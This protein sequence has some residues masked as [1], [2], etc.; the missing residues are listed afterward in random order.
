[1]PEKAL[2]TSFFKR[3]IDIVLSLIALIVL[4][5][6]MLLLAVLIRFKLGS[7]VLFKQ[8]R[9]GK[10]EQV[11]DLYKF[12]TMT[13]AKGKNGELL[14]D[15]ERLTRFGKFVRS[16][17]LDELPSLINIIKGDM[18]IV[19]PR[20]LLI[21]Y[22]ALY[23]DEQKKRHLLKPGLTGWAQVNGR[24]A[25]TWEQRF[26]NDIYYIENISFMLDVRIVCK[27]FVKVFKRSGVSASGQATMEKFEGDK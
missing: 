1:M 18:S 7:P 11:F 26:A 3:L 15:S 20:P 27:T 22:L 8:V 9:P 4:F 23:N 2:Y 13:D 24:N 19:G 10:N 6:I 12:R 14:P 5:P 21:E 16:T 17:S 25:T